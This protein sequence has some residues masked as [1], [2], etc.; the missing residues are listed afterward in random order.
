MLKH[1]SPQKMFSSG[2][3][4]LSSCLDIEFC[5]MNSIF[6][7]TL[8]VLC[9]QTVNIRK[10][11]F[12]KIIVCSLLAVFKPVH[13]VTICRPKISPPKVSYKNQ[14]M[15]YKSLP[16]GAF[17]TIFGQNFPTGVPQL[18]YPYQP[19]NPLVESMFKALNVLNF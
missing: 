7:S 3:F 1:K 15:P 2:M 5:M 16:L 6:R 19:A 4:D 12:R 14:S 11:E 8:S 13:R 18:L 17:W 10:I 9:V